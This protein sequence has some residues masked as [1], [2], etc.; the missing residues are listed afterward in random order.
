MEVVVRIVAIRVV[1][2]VLW[3]SLEWFMAAIGAEI[4]VSGGETR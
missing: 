1:V 4:R 2:F 3:V